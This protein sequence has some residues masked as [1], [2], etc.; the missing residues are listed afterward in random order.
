MSDNSAPNA[1]DTMSA[2]ALQ[3]YWEWW[4]ELGVDQ[5]YVEAPQGWFEEETA[6]AP[7]N[8]KPSSTRQ[9]PKP[10]ARVEE[11]KPPPDTDIAL[12]DTLDALLQWWPESDAL[13]TV[14]GIG[15]SIAP[16]VQAKPRLLVISDM[17]DEDDSDALFSGAAGTM[18]DAILHAIGISR[19][20][21][22][23]VSILPQYCADADAELST[24]PFWRKL[25]AHQTGLLQPEYVMLC[26]KTANMA[27]TEKDLAENRRSLR[28]INLN[29][30]NIPA[31]ASFHPRSL[32]KTP[33]IKGSAWRDWLRLKGLM[34]G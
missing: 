14:S 28:F 12:P 18:L 31:S 23:F 30:G 27:V 8:P 26:S 3:S 34:N 9:T 21:C 7:I 4:Q 22:A 16:T 17:P 11:Q 25:V 29:G 1:A 32:A 2:E 20:H 13:K 24:R 10:I 6:P 19:N 15:P 33:A 5:D